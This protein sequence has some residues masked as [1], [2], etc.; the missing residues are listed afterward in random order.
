MPAGP[1]SPDAPSER[2]LIA[3]AASLSLAVYSCPLPPALLLRRAP[4]QGFQCILNTELIS[5]SSLIFHM[6][7]R[8][9]CLTNYSTPLSISGFATSLGKTAKHPA[10]MWDEFDSLKSQIAMSKPRRGGRRTLP[11]AFISV[12]HSCVPGFLISF[13]LSALHQTSLS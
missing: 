4:E 3:S 12:I 7:V 8:P 6:E 11:Y 2:L 5:Y 10:A 9:D 13:P 1:L